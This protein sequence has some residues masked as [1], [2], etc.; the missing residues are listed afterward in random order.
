MH[1]A[2]FVVDAEGPRVTEDALDHLSGTPSAASIG[3]IDAVTNI[4]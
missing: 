1:L 2:R 3:D 4:V